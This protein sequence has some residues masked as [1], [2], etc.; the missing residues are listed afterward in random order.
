MN[1]YFIKRRARKRAIW[2]IVS[3]LEEIFYKEKDYYCS[4][5]I[6]IANRDRYIESEHFIATLDGVI[7]SL[8]DISNPDMFPE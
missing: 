6:T 5:P 3:A 8:Y 4:I 2:L 7:E 1:N